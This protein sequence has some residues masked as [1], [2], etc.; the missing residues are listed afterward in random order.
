[1][2]IPVRMEDQVAVELQLARLEGLLQCIEHEDHVP[3][4]LPRLD[5]G[6]L[7]NSH[8]LRSLG[9]E[10]LRFQLC[11]ASSLGS[12]ARFSGL[13]GLK[14]KTSKIRQTWVWPKR[15]PCAFDDGARAPER[16]QLRAKFIPGG[17]AQ[18][19][20]SQH[21]GLLLVKLGRSTPLRQGSQC[22]DP[23]PIEQPL[24]RAL[25][26]ATRSIVAEMESSDQPSPLFGHRLN[27]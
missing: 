2:A 27:C 24:P 3:P 1:M 20:C 8:Q 5:A 11:T 13:Y 25:R 18:E 23:T 21:C 6:E 14:T 17:I 10:L 26:T 19:H 7:Q 16:P 4:A 12:T 15:P 22:I 9:P